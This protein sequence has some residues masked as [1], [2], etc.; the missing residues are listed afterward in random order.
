M[1]TMCGQAQAGRTQGPAQLLA[2]A[3]TACVSQQLLRI[4]QPVLAL[5][6]LLLGREAAA[7]VLTGGIPSCSAKGSRYCC[8]IALLVQ[9][10]RAV[11]MPSHNRWGCA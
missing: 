3:V 8:C 5:L 6:L 7:A 2:A 11:C 4:C 10:A 9:C 1:L